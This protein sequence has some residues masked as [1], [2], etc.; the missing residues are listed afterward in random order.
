MDVLGKQLKPFPLTCYPYIMAQVE[1]VLTPL[2]WN[3]F[4]I[5]RSG[6]KFFEAAL[7][8]C[9]AIATPI[10]NIDRFSSPLLRKCATVEE[11][12]KALAEQVELDPDLV[13][14]EIDKIIAQI[15]SD[16]VSPTWEKEFLS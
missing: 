11:W 10:P 6:L 16:V 5:C 7:V 12:E 13:G 9:Q 2:E 14:T 3:D 4:T 8:G 1:T 15:A